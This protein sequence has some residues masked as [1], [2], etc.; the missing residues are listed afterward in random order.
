MSKAAARS[1]IEDTNTDEP[2]QTEGGILRVVEEID[3][4]LNMNGTNFGW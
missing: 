1:Y 4:Q 2:M 3:A